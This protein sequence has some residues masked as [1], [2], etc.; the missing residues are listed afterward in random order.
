MPTTYNLDITPTQ[1]V[2]AQAYSEFPR[3]ILFRS[4]KTLLFCYSIE[5]IGINSA[6]YGWQTRLHAFYY[7]Y[8]RREA[9][10]KKTFLSN[11]QILLVSRHFI[12]SIATNLWTNVLQRSFPIMN[13]SLFWAIAATTLYR[14]LTAWRTDIL[15]L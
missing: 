9:E 3:L 1:F 8:N 11:W 13:F 10:S 7:I 4:V 14:K 12:L 15:N 2:L 6:F 5:S